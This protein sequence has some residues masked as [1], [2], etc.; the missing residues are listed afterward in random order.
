MDL[1]RFILRRIY[2]IFF[3]WIKHFFRVFIS[4]IG[5]FITL[6]IIAFFL[7][8]V[9]PLKNQLIQKIEEGLPGELIKLKAKSI[10]DYSNPLLLFQKNHDITYG[11][12]PE[13]ISKI[14]KWKEVRSVHTT[15][16]LQKPVL[17]RLRHPFLSS[18][19]GGLR[20]D[21]LLQGV[22]K[23]LIRPYLRCMKDFKPRTKI[24]SSEGKKIREIT[25]PILIPDIYL[26]IAR[27]WLSLNGLPPID[28]KKEKRF[29]LE[30][31]IGSSILKPKSEE[32]VQVKGKICGFLPEGIVST[33]GVPIGWVKNFHKS[34]EMFHASRSYDQIFVEVKNIKDIQI[35]N[36]RFNK[37]GLV[38]SAKPKKY[39]GLY[40]WLS[41]LDYFFW[42]IVVVLLVLSGIHLF[43]YFT[44]LAV[45]KKYEFGLYMIFGAS[46]FF[47]WTIM[48][49]EGGIWGFI[50]SMLS[51]LGAEFILNY[52]K[53]NQAILSL[54][55]NLLHFHFDMS[56]QEK[57]YLILGAVFFSGIASMFPSIILMYKKT[58]SLVRKD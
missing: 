58:L 44:L 6:L 48:F 27:L 26:E 20:F 41:K 34:N 54:Y 57:I 18:L 25:L 36:K 14:R 39:P 43:H 46:P 10:D 16:T 35:L 40:N 1:I 5:L 8:I 51:I 33:V 9:R 32:V 47:I 2:L 3:L 37:M 22:S 50:H 7:G 12:T 24:Y 42:G 49:L 28:I 30:M 45:E 17:T 13:Q 55:P 29:E 38:Y 31:V 52:L 21:V 11:V 19:G 23:K 56:P 15:Q 53:G 4:S